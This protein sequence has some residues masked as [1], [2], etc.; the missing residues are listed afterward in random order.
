MYKRQPEYDPYAQD[1]KLKNLLDNADASKRDSIKNDAQDVTTTKS[2]T[3]TNV[4][5]LKTDGKRPKIWSV[6]NFDFNYSYIQTISHNPLI[7][8]DEMRRTR[9]AIGYAYSPQV[10]TV[11]P[12]R[13][14]IKSKS[15]WFALIKD[16]NFNY[17]PSSISFRADVFR[18]FGATRPRNVGGGPYQIP[19]TYNK[20]YTFDRY[21]ICLLYTS[22][23]V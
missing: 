21:Y 9:G 12:F 16:F 11:E 10:K 14:L 2:I 22:R 5:K 19:E 13:K 1:L 3:L 18:Q 23:C 6:S 15:P 20:Y 7:E 4:R 17:A 8:N